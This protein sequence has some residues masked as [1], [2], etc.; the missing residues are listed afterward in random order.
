[1]S[2]VLGYVNAK[3]AI[4]MSDGRAGE[5]G[6][7]S[8]HYNK[9]MKINDNIIIGFARILEPIEFFLEHVFSQMGNDRSSYYINDFL[10]M[11]N[12]FMNDKETQENLKSD[13]IIIGRTENGQ[14]ISAIVGDSTNYQIEQNL[15]TSPR[16]LLIGGTIALSTLS[17]IYKE[18]ISNH[19][20][21]IESCM[22]Q[23]IRD[24]AVLDSSI[25]GNIFGQMI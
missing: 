22:I 18:N 6:S 24:A 8:E 7:Y 14:M 12:F 25:N 4:I 9:T 16:L 19:N 10:Y 20:I 3:N 17:K 5:N 11:I 15:V 1:M 21:P 23:T 2:L 13:F